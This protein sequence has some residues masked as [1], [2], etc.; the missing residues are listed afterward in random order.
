MGGWLVGVGYDMGILGILGGVLLGGMLGFR[1]GYFFESC[2]IL[3]CFYFM[4]GTCRL[5]LNVL[6]LFF[7]F[8]LSFSF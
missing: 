7:F 4:C 2:F 8:S 3:G 6:G 5:S 1:G